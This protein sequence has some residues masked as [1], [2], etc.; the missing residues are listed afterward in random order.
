MSFEEILFYLT[1]QQAIVIYIIVSLS[2]FIENIFPPFPSD[3][4]TLVGAFLAGRGELGYMQLYLSVIIGGLAGAMVLYYLGRSKGR[5]FFIRYDSYYLK[6]EN[7]HKIE[8]LFKKWVDPILIVSRFMAG[9]RSVVA[10]TAGI[11]NVPVSRM[12]IF[13]LISFCL[14]YAILIGGMFLLK[15]NWQKLVEFIRSYNVILVVVSAL[16]IMAW[17]IIVYKKSGIKK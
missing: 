14:W 4:I 3:T 1:T 12:I 16:V 11:G 8:R 17:L 10:L 9:V 7:M 13:T 5:R 6:L 15:S 2:A